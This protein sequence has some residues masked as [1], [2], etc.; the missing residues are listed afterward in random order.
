M[1]STLSAA[2]LALIAQTAISDGESANEL[3]WSIYATVAANRAAAPHA[4]VLGDT[5]AHAATPLPAR[6]PRPRR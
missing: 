3:R 5:R 4:S 6:R 1:T 2:M